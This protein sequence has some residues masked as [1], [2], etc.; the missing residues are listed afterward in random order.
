M[1]FS[2]KPET[3]GDMDRVVDAHRETWGSRD[4][5]VWVV[6]DITDFDKASYSL[7]SYYAGK[8]HDLRATRAAMTVMVTDNN[9]SK[10]SAKLYELVSSSKFTQARTLDEA[11]AIVK[12]EQAKLGAFVP[13]D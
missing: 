11:L 13:L 6:S 1:K 9:E 12:L 10:F 7:V 8:M 3:F 4:H 5:K 2:G